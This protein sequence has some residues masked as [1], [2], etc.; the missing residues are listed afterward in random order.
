M[1]GICGEVT[2]GLTPV[3]AR[4]VAVMR[5]CLVHRGPDSAGLYVS[6]TA[7]AALGFRRLKIIDLSDAADQ[8]LPNED[9][10]VQVVFNGE[11]YNFAELRKSLLS[12]G[13]Q[14]RSRSDTEVIVH[15]YEEYGDECIDRLDGMFAIG[16]WDDRQRRLLLARD[17]SGK[18]PLYYAHRDDRIVFASEMKAFLWRQDLNIEIDP[19][20]FA[21]YFI[22]G[23]VPC[24]QTFYAGVRQLEPATVMLFDSGGR[25]KARR[26]WTL[27]F[28]SEA[29]QGDERSNGADQ[30]RHLMGEAVRRRLIADVPLGAFLSGGIDSTIVVGLMSK[31]VDRV[32]TFSIGFSGS[33]AY[34]ERSYA[35]LVAERFNTDHTEFVV[36]PC[37]FDLIESL[38]W[39]HD[40]PFGDSSAVPTYIVSRLTRQKVTV[41]LTGD[42]AD[43][44]FAGYERFAASLAAE[45]MPGVLREALTVIGRALP[46]GETQRHMLSRVKRFAKAANLSLIQ[47]LTFWAGLFY[48]D[49]EE[50]L[51]GNVESGDR[52]QYLNRFRGELRGI[53]PLNQML[54]VNFHTYLLD[55]LL[56][57]TDRC[58]MANSLEARC[59]FLDTAVIEFS[60]SL[61][62]SA[63]LN[64]RRSK[65]LL[66]EAFVDL[67]PPEVLQRK[68]MGFGVPFGLWFRTSL[69]EALHDLL[70]APAPRYAEYLSPARVRELIRRHELGEGD[71][72]LQLWA[73]L[74]FE[75]WL[76]SVPNWL[77]DP[78][79]QPATRLA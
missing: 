66:R 54:L 30:L 28:P 36:E 9:G 69:R 52:L 7:S 37:A 50:L 77:R 3:D 48:D 35:R 29:R 49:L 5:D 71:F 39:H 34:D 1:C 57:K 55:D 12:R 62:D 61:R 43:E 46:A 11:I 4:R 31:F 45:S 40:G 15:L 32:R 64:N 14:F 51:Q 68:K 25:A 22:Y 18:K 42:G 38:V 47:R 73:I 63:K 67:I 44:L 79:V 21:P 60:A 16:I 33:H 74:C 65:T 23:Y 20:T 2:F 70:L 56:V 8:P 76:R 72:E 75:C 78:A 6:P 24:P 27:R 53:S 19:A 13:H 10:S 41:V 59:P 58:T 26:Y 17:R